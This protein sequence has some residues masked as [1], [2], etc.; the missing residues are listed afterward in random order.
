MDMHGAGKNNRILF[1]K[2][3]IIN[4][5]VAKQLHKHL[6]NKSLLTRYFMYLKYPLCGAYGHTVKALNLRSMGLGFDSRNT[7]HV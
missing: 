6:I 2:V 4:I 7:G 1:V 5:Q 3:A